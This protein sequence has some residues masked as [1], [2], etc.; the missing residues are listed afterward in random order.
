MRTYTHNPKA[1]QQKTS[2]RPLIHDQEQLGQGRKI[3]PIIRLQRL[4]GN[5]KVLRMLESNPDEDLDEAEPQS[6]AS[7]HTALGPDIVR[8]YT[9][10]STYHL[11]AQIRQAASPA[12]MTGFLASNSQSG[13]SAFGHEADSV[14]A[15]ENE[16]EKVEEEE[17]SVK[18]EESDSVGPTLTYSPSIA[19]DSTPPGASEFGVTRTNPT[20]SGIGVTHDDAAKAFNVTATVVNTVKWSVHSLTRTDI[21]NETAPAI[22][23]DNY[24]TVASDLTPNMSSDNGRPPRTKFWAQDLTERHEKF[25]ANERA[26]TYGKPAFEFA[27]TWLK[28]QTATDEAGARS[29]VNQIPDK[30]FESYDASYVPGK[31]SRAYG[32]G[33]PSYKARADA[34]KKKGDEGGY[35]GGTPTP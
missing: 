24:T 15:G 27:Q 25:H 11:S 32:D 21:P 34:I 14:E 8:T 10:S 9:T 6:P 18:V 5:Q 12:S 28:G 1:T 13:R 31:E 4:V 3:D 2:A 23:K 33:A 30:M 7:E 29:L 22:T 19:T 17:G 20:V 26:N 35:G 16:P